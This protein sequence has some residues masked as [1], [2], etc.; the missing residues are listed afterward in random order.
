MNALFIPS[1]A[2]GY[3][4]VD[5]ASGAHWGLILSKFENCTASSHPIGTVY[6]CRFAVLARPEHCTA[7]HKLPLGYWDFLGHFNPQWLTMTFFVNNSQS[8]SP[9]MDMPCGT[10]VR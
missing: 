6:I 5:V 7:L 2:V 9:R 8:P 4:S 3:S 1:R 10:P